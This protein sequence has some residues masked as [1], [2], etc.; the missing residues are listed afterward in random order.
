MAKK[1]EEKKEKQHTR[2]WIKPLVFT[3]SGIF[4]FLLIVGLSLVW[5][6]Q[7]YAQKF[8]PGVHIGAT[9]VSGQSYLDV[10]TRLERYSES[11]ES[12]GVEFIYQD[13]RVNVT[14]S[15]LATSDPDLAV[16][17]FSFY[18]EP[19]VQAAYAHGR[20]GT[21]WQ[22]TM[23]QIRSF[24]FG[25]HEA[26]Q[27]EV[28]DETLQGLLEESFAAYETA[29]QDAQLEVNEAHTLIVAP[30]EAG[31][32]LAYSDAIVM[33]KQAFVKQESRIEIALAAKSV[34]PRYTSADLQ[35]LLPSAEQLLTHAPFILHSSD[36]DNE[37]S[38]EELAPWL[39]AR[40]ATVGVLLEVSAERADEFFTTLAEQIDEAPQEGRF[41]IS[42]GVVTETQPGKEGRSLDR[43]ATAQA[44]TQAWIQE[45]VQSAE[46]VMKV[47]EPQI[48]SDATG[49]LQNLQL[50]G[51]G[52]SNFA[53]SPN[54]RR[55]N[56]QVGA[57]SVN[58]V[59]VMPG[60][61][62]SLVN[63]L[64]PIEKET[65]Y[66]PELVIKGDKTVPEYG[67]GLC[68]I[69]TT[70]FRAAMATALPITERRNHSY[71]VSYYLE[72]GLPGT[73]ATIYPAH[74]DLRFVNDTENPILIQS[75]I[76]G[77]DIY[78][79]FWGKS[80]GRSAVRTTPEVW[81]WTDPPPT[82][83]IVSTDLAPGQRKCTERAHKGVKTQF[84]YTITYPDGHQEE[85][86]F[87]STY[88]P[89]QEVC[90]VGPSET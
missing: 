25:Y 6:Q 19:T 29:A 32:T 80:D 77:N 85:K 87:Q 23:T 3:L 57:D 13:T 78:F 44:M 21:Y 76:E 52:H 55:H 7:A 47:Q 4:L 30:E 70:V 53:G 26:L 11:V 68:Q 22:N 63:I 89:W 74:P 59:V 40:P 86:V 48:T 36:G 50:L 69:G 49:P 75:R 17:L 2:T 62:F 34:A 83:E 65:G 12:D 18:V 82:K 35:P 45:G 39:I 46:V 90:L 64:G 9:S 73:D 37:I 1:K 54:N 60:E 10:L 67:G 27:Y 88:K 5:L 51:T 14:P 66:L 20:S 16:S 31:E 71:N 72:N 41:A 38:K 8:Y 81:G 61:E 42:D 58:G 84:T 79:D 56:I 33:M 43:E 24:V 15:V 28:A